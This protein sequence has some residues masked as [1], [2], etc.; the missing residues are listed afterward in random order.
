MIGT[1][2]TTTTFVFTPTVEL[3]PASN[4][5]PKVDLYHVAYYRDE[6]NYDDLL[7][8][9]LQRTSVMQKHLA[10]LSGR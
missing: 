4:P 6:T 3:Q 1:T 2:A 9:L 10:S 8:A 7:K 5:L